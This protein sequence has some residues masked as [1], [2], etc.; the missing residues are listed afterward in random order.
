MVITGSTGSGKTTLMNLMLGF[1]K[2][3]E[4]NIFIMVKMFIVYQEFGLITQAMFHNL[5]I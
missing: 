4:G 3:S 2:P 5:V 1:L